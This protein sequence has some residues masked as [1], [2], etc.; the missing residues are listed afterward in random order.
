MSALSLQWVS[1]VQ[2]QLQLKALQTSKMLQAGAA[3][4]GLHLRLLDYH[5]ASFMAALEA[6]G[7]VG[8]WAR[9]ALPLPAGRCL[10]HPCSDL[11]AAHP[12]TA[13]QQVQQQYCALWQQLDARCCLLLQSYSAP[14]VAPPA[15]AT[16]SV[17]ADAITFG[18]T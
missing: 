1:G 12:A 11:F 4:A 7:A 9:K 8:G 18:L 5:W 3:L 14:D 2:S 17:V 15:T 13:C 6:L 10:L 16:Q